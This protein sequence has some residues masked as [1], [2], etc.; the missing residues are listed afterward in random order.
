MTLELSDAAGLDGSSVARRDP[1]SDP[2]GVGVDPRSAPGLC[3]VVAGDDRPVR[4]P[5]PPGGGPVRPSESRGPASGRE[6]AARSALE[7]QVAFAHSPCPWLPPSPPFW[8]WQ[9][10]RGAVWQG[11]RQDA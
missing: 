6:Q 5:V 9:F 10:S 8:L 3:R 2:A 11:S 4:P 1:W 7:R